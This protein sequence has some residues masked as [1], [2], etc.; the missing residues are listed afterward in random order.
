[1]YSELY[2]SQGDHKPESNGAE[3]PMLQCHEQ[4]DSHD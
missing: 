3:Q 2:G 1:M 4:S